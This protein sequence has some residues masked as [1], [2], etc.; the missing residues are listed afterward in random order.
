MSGPPNRPIL[1]STLRRY[2]LTPA[3]HHPAALPLA[4]ILKAG[5]RVLCVAQAVAC[6]HCKPELS[7]IH[8]YIVRRMV[9]VMAECD[10]VAA[11]VTPWHQ[12]LLYGR[13]DFVKCVGG[14]A[15]SA[16]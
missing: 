9:I 1:I 12:R 10:G 3:Q 13:R 7:G 2:S 15:L 8:V 11:R 14:G 16:N 6:C 4:C 5:I